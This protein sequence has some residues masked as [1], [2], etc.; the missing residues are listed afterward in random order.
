MEFEWDRDKE[1]SNFK[2]HGVHF[3]EATTLFGDPFEVTILDPDHSIDEYR[4]LS[5]GISSTGRILVVS[6]VER[7]GD[8][9]RIVSAREASQREQRQ[10]ETRD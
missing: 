4:F 2:K 3:A 10:Y 6:Y 5:V 8:R 1:Q 7:P 9:I